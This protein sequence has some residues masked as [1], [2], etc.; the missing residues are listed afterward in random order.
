MSGKI[1]VYKNLDNANIVLANG[2]NI[3]NITTTRK[4]TEIEEDQQVETVNTQLINICFILDMSP[5]MTF[6][7]WRFK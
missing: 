3:S 7:R 1:A 4:I 2:Q 5:S 6:N